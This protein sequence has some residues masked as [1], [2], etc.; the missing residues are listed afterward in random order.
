MTSFFTKTACFA[1]IPLNAVKG[2]EV[3]IARESVASYTDF[4][5]EHLTSPVEV[6]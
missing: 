6:Q 5:P 1:A 4:V 2:S 3:F